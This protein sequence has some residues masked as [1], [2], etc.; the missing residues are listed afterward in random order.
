MAV[1]GR[2]P[3]R[4]PGPWSDDPHG[5]TALIPASDRGHVDMVRALLGTGIAIDHI[6]DLGWTA[7][8]EAVILGDGGPAHQQIVR[9]L[10]EAGLM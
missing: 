9:A 2:R 5:G 3:P 7:L 4:G 6:N 8:L 10:L 1:G